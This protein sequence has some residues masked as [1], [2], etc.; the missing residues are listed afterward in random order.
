M[1]YYVALDMAAVKVSEGREAE[2]E[3]VILED[4]GV[5]MLP[6]FTT[7]ERFQGFFE[8]A[9]G[10]GS[11]IEPL[12]THPF[13]LAEMVARM[14]ATGELKALIFNPLRVSHEGWRMEHEPIPV[15]EYLRFVQ[16]I[17]PGIEKLAAESTAKFGLG[18]PSSEVFE[19]GMRWSLPKLRKLVENVEARMGE[20]DV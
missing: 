10:G 1:A 7:A 13:E 8:R 11:R 16:E 20:W 6:V 3:A 5:P 17:R 4:E 14:E 18:P 2:V 19:K 9:S 15:E 12:A